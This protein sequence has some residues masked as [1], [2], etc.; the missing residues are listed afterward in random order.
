MNAPIL[1]DKQGTPA[2]P[3]RGLLDTTLDSQ[4]KD[5]PLAIVGGW[6]AFM[7]GLAADG[8]VDSPASF[9]VAGTV[10]AVIFATSSSTCSS[11]SASSVSA[12]LVLGM[13]V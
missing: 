12:T 5:R 9:G 3:T 4:N 8:T 11:R 7:I 13:M 10:G 1:A 2:R 6:L